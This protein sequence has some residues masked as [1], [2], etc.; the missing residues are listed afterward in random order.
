MDAEECSLENQRMIFRYILENPGTHLRRIAEGT[1]I[2]L[3]TLRYHIAFLEKRD[4]VISRREGNTRAF[5]ING[6]VSAVDRRITPLL[7]QKRFRDIVTLLLARPGLGFPEIASAL[8]LKPSTL[9]KYLSIVEERGIVR[10]EVTGREKRYTVIDERRIVELLLTY[11][12]SFWDR[13]VDNALGIY[14]ER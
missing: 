11:R 12:R 1:D 5:F 13:F 10:V 6:R 2:P 9:S 4:V 3:S 8:D 7:Q 14:F